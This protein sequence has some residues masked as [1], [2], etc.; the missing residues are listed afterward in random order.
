M[1][2]KQGKDMRWRRE[3]GWENGRKGALSGNGD[4]E[5]QGG[6]EKERDMELEI[7]ER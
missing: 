5:K 3:R 2:R 7:R 6:G 4:R 1:W